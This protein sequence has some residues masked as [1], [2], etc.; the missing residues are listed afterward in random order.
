MAFFQPRRY[1]IFDINWSIVI[2]HSTSIGLT[3]LLTLPIAWNRES[4]TTSAGIRTFPLVGVAACGFT[5]IAMSVL[6][7]LDAQARIV[8]GIIT[9]IGFIGGGAIL[10][11]D[12][13][14][15][16]TATAASIWTTGA[17]GV[18]VAWDRLEIAILLSAITFVTLKF[19]S[20]TKKIIKD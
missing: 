12:K 8:Q 9:G 3:Y 7:N 11:N 20:K 13:D 15:S 19:M 2:S 17:I 1:F 5:L 10:K 6:D 18:A 4:E 16:G 14:V